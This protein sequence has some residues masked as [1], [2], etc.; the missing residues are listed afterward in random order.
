M[1]TPQLQQAIRLLKLSTPELL[2]AVQQ[3]IN[4]NPVLEFAG[5]EWDAYNGYAIHNSWSWQKR[6]SYDPLLHA[7]SNEVSLERHLKEQLSFIKNIPP[8]IRRI[9]MFMIGNLDNNGYLGS[10]WMKFRNA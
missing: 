3:E 8:A 2:E 4:E 1:I 10:P 9:F 6:P 5:N 7:A